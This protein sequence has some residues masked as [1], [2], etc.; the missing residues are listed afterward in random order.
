MA[1]IL[2]LLAF[3][4]ALTPALALPNGRQYGQVDHQ[5]RSPQKAYCGKDEPTVPTY[6]NSREPRL[7]LPVTTS[8]FDEDALPMPE[9]QGLT[10]RTVALGLG[11]QNYTCPNA[12]ASPILVGARARLFNAESYLL[13]Q[14]LA[15]KDIPAAYLQAYE[16]ATS[17]ETCTC[18]PTDLESFPC[19]DGVNAISS[20]PAFDLP[21]VGQHY[22]NAAGTPIFNITQTDE[23]AALKLAV[24]KTAGAQAP[25]AAYTGQSSDGTVDWLFLEDDGEGFSVGAKAV[26]RVQTA[27]G[28]PPAERCASGESG[29]FEVEYAAEYWFYE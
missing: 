11:T 12:T 2:S 3:M 20:L 23:S 4:A 6:E 22:F 1:S 9:S 10:L 27:G 24:A 18:D 29:E 21:I 19:E 8:T 14:T 7:V 26:Y 28:S 15:D 13:D 16:S 25:Q 5:K 17:T